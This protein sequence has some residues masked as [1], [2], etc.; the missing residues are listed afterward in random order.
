MASLMAEV[1]NTC[2][3]A[4]WYD[5]ACWMLIEAISAHTSNAGFAVAF[6]RV[7]V[8]LTALGMVIETILALA[9]SAK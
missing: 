9:P 4:I 8:D 1:T 5:T 3:R 6:R 2:L 7:E